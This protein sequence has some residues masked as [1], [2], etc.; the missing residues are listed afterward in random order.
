LTLID[1]FSYISAYAQDFQVP[2][3]FEALFM[4]S[5]GSHEI[6][7]VPS[8][9]EPVAAKNYTQ[10]ALMHVRKDTSGLPCKYKQNLTFNLN[11]D[12]IG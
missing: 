12:G 4:A 3:E 6:P 8:T 11:F 9:E 2:P 1:L 7:D 5:L 10:E